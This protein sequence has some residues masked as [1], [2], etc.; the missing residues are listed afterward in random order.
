M[1]NDV[2]AINPEIQAAVVFAK[3][4]GVDAESD[5]QRYLC[6][7]KPPGRIDE[8]PSNAVSLNLESFRR[9]EFKAVFEIQ[10]ATYKEVNKNSKER[11]DPF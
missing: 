5:F 8:N 9:K 2:D 4:L 3:R 7:R 10:M 6:H 1:Y 11:K